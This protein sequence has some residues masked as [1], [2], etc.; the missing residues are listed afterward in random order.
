MV[1][2][3]YNLSFLWDTKDSIQANITPEIWSP[4]PLDSCSEIAKW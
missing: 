1:L 4:P 3:D 2:Y